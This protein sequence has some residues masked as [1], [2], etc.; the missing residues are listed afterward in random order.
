[1]IDRQATAAI[2]LAIDV[3]ARVLVRAGAS[4][5]AL[6]FV[7]LAIGWRAALAIALN[8]YEIGALAIL[9]SRLFD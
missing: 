3:L 9:L 7:G 8:A 1:M 2:R 5:D 4:A 6:S